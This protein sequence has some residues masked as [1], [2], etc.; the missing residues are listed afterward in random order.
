MEKDNLRILVCGGRNYANIDKLFEILSEYY[1]PIIIQ[2]GARGADFLA[3]HYAC[4][5]NLNLITF[6]A[7]WDKYGKAA[8]H[9]RNKQML[10]EGKPNL[11]I[12]FPGGRGTLN[13]IQQT[14][15]AG[16]QLR[17]IDE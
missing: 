14:K 4:Q 13:M 1:R 11:V 5:N 12:A 6:N 15:K 10:E 7:N 8:G 2:G 3:K 17:I 16:I 9:I